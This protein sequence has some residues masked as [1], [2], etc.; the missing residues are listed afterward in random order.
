MPKYTKAQLLKLRDN[1]DR[2]LKKIEKDEKNN[3]E[4]LA[5]SFGNTKSTID[6][7]L[8]SIKNDK[9]YDKLSILL[10]GLKNE[11]GN[12]IK[13]TTPDMGGVIS[14]I[15][16]LTFSMKNKKDFDDKGIVMTLNRIEKLLS[17]KP[18]EVKGKD[19]SK[20]VVK[21]LKNLKI[22]AG[23]ME[24]P[25]SIAINN[26]PP[27][28]IAQPVSHMSIN[29]LSGS[30]HPTSTTVKTTLTSLPGYG[31][32]DNRRAIIF[33]NNDSTNTVFIGGSTV[34]TSTGMP[35]EAKSFS[36]SFDSGPLQKWYGVTSSGTADVRC[37]ELPDEAS[38]R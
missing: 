1:T 13:A 20:E 26:F 4:R 36:P 8:S 25:D 11:L 9:T 15:R 16:Q 23:S 38:G 35:I 3:Y 6:E 33:Y 37:L 30:V 32:L 10:N 27:Q 2:L 21:A 7:V 22:E 17:K 24:F 5:L 12:T 31:V 34:T 19:S 18:K 14:E 28:K 29:S